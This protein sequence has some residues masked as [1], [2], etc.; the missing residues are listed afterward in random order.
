MKSFLTRAWFGL[1]IVG[2]LVAHFSGIETA[3]AAGQG[4]GQLIYGEG[5]VATPRNR[6]FDNASGT[7]GAETSLPSNSTTNLATILKASPT[8]NEMIAGI[9]NSSGTLNVYLWNGTSWTSQWT[10]NTGIGTTPRFAITYEEVS[11]DAMVVYSRNNTADEMQ[12]RIWNGSS[13]TSATNLPSER[14][15]GTVHFIV[16]KTRAG[17]DEIGLLWA[18]SARDLSAQ[19]WNGS[20]WVGE[21]AAVLENDLG[22]IA[23]SAAIEGPVADLAFEEQSGRLMVV[24]GNNSGTNF[25]HVIRAANGTW[26][27]V[28]SPA[29]F[30]QQAEVI[31]LASRA[32]TNQIA[33][34]TSSNW[35]YTSGGQSEK[36]EASIWNGSSWI[37]PVKFN[38]G[39]TGFVGQMDVGV[40]WMTSGGITKALFSYNGPATAGVDYFSYDP[41]TGFSG[42]T[43]ETASPAP[44]TS[45]DHLHRLVLNPFDSSQAILILVDSNNDLFTR[46]VAFNGS[47][48]TWSSLDGGASLETSTPTSSTIQ[49]W[50][51]DFAFQRY[52]PPVGSLNSDI[53]DGSGMP[54]ASPSLAMNATVVSNNCQ[55]TTGTFGTS[56]QK[57]RIDNTTTT[58]GWTLTMA[59]SAGT[60][61]S[62][63]SGTTSYDFNDSSG[64]GCSDGG[65][66]DSVAGQLSVN[67]S[68]IT[69]TPQGGCSAT[70]INAGSAS[71]FAQGSVDS[72]TLATASAGAQT[73]CYWDITGIALSQKIPAYTPAG[74]YSITMT[75]TATAN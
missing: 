61:A 62:W 60:G 66:A 52:F 18:D 3:H 44:A 42:T 33:Y 55:T 37:T 75:I 7:W 5:T 51:A 74:N 31:Q 23:G 43:F 47:A 29:G 49:G 25:R 56:S 38:A 57:I 46:K 20:S 24:W 71:A 28:V 30:T 4:D 13:W 68:G 6:A 53:I 14:T 26:G 67:P 48:F 16:A 64:S 22:Q 34:I 21:P 19:F 17:T 2:L 11:G 63:A 32:G 54:V 69:V 12:Y 65:D 59:A 35:S 41:S 10:F 27:S 40:V 73:H 1:V 70:G 45:D 50:V 58:P 15:N 36:V 8:R 72:I 9:V 39:T